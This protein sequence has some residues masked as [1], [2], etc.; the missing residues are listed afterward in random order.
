MAYRPSGTVIGQRSTRPTMVM[1]WSLR[2][3]SPRCPPQNL[4]TSTCLSGPRSVPS[5]AHPHALHRRQCPKPY[6]GVRVRERVV[7]LR[8]FRDSASLEARTSSNFSLSSASGRS[9]HSEFCRVSPLDIFHV[10]PVHVTSLICGVLDR[11]SDLRPG[12]DCEMHSF[13]Q[14]VPLR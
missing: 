12:C 7:P 1:L 6:G 14:W 2:A 11:E 5:I 3:R 13:H 4:I 9:S 8:R 10:Q